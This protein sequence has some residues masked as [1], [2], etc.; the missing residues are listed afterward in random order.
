MLRLFFS[1][2]FAGSILTVA[3]SPGLATCGTASLS[4]Y[5]A[6]SVFPGG[7]CAIGILDYYSFSYHPTSNAP[8]E[9][10][11]VV[12]PTNQGFGF[13]LAGGLPF[14]A[15]AGQIVQFE[16]DYNIL[17]DPAPEVDGASFSLD[18]PSGNVVITG[19]FCND[20]QYVFSGSCFGSNVES[21]SVGTQAPFSPTASI[22]F[23]NPAQR[24]EELGILF[25]LDA[26]GNNG[27]ASFDGLV[28]TSSVL[29]L[30]PEPGTTTTIILGLLAITGG[31][32]LKRPRKR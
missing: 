26:S 10:N 14:T 29:Y 6:S 19:F 8:L 5:Q 24:F 21:L 31:C 32:R 15:S 18:P 1:L 9:S 2:L 3:G 25:T 12:T 13:T 4:D 30:T 22:K 7:G 20:S 17:I 23:V 28:A 11:I 27:P 16:I